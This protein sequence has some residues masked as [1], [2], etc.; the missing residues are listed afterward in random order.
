M[1]VNILTRRLGQNRITA[2]TLVTWVALM[3]G[4]YIAFISFG[5][6]QRTALG[7]GML[8]T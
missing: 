7:S 4:F 5:R 2:R 1:M 8:C 3:N 6:W